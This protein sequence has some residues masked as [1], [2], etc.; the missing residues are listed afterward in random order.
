MR[1]ISVKPPLGFSLSRQRL[2]PVKSRF[3]RISRLVLAETGRGAEQQRQQE[4]AGER[5]I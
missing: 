2:E 3:I 1:D 5:F 4:T